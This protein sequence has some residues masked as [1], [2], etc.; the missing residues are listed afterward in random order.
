VR[1]HV[2]ELQVQTRSREDI[3]IITGG[4]E[5]AV[6]RSGIKRGIALI[7]VPHATAMLAVNE[8][9]PRLKEDILSKLRQLFPRNA[10]YRHDEIDDNANAHLANVFLGPHLVVP[11]I[12]G[13][14]ARGTWQD[15]MIIEM[16]GPRARRV[17]VVVVGE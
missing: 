11:V 8:N 2:E 15:V 14:A 4:I 3:V 9:E 13:R 6:E 1:V 12:D 5:S 16:D 7:Y 17:T 10:G